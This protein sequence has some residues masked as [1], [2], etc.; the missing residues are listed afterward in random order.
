MKGNRSSTILMHEAWHGLMGAKIFDNYVLFP[1]TQADL[2]PLLNEKLSFPTVLVIGRWISTVPRLFTF[3]LNKNIPMNKRKTFPFGEIKT[4][5][6]P[7]SC[8]HNKHINL[9]NFSFPEWLPTEERT[10]GQYAAPAMASNAWIWGKR[11]WSL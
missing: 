8:N 7:E 4:K 2:S 10:S 6:T 5:K 11:K 9:Q 1:R 3:F